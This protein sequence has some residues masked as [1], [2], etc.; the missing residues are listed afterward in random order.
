MSD[1]TPHA[2]G[3]VAPA[4]LT[5]P[6]DLLAAAWDELRLQPP[7]REP[8]PENPST[9][10]TDP[11]PASGE[12]MAPPEETPSP[13]ASGQAKDAAEAPEN[14]SETLV[15]SELENEPPEPEPAKHPAEGRDEPVQLTPTAIVEAILFA[16]DL[17][18]PA[19]KIAE[20]AE[21]EGAAEA[22][23]LI[24][25]LNDRY[26]TANAAY[27]V[28]NLAGGYQLLSLPHFNPWLSKL[29]AGRQ[30]SRLSP[31]AL[32]T[33]ALVAYKQPVTRAAVEAIRGVASGEVLRSLME[34]GL[35][36]MAGRAE[37]LGRPMLYATTKKFLRIFGLSSVK[38]LPNPEKSVKTP[39]L[40]EKSENPEPRS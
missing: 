16:T 23:R 31:S 7:D 35:V 6:R 32:E 27:R 17:P 10:P 15:A 1:S 12:A 21:L 37:E 39:E 18:L 22:K 19:A 29:R 5:S 38:D 9:P 13:F 14:G 4:G 30:E 26:R 20:I 8:E 34:R 28:E 40:P 25:E 24:A 36:K 2:P 3:P 11:E 33:L